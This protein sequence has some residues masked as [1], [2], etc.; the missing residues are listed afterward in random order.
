VP[1][2]GSRSLVKGPKSFFLQP[3]E[4][5]EK[6]EGTNHTIRK[7]NILAPDDGIWVTAVEEFH[8]TRNTSRV[9]KLP[10]DVWL[11]AGPGL[12][13]TPIEARIQKRIKAFLKFEP[14]N[15][16]FFQPGLFFGV[17]VVVLILLYLLLFRS[18]STVVQKDL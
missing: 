8:E 12:Y 5:L 17:I 6:E 10:G 16:Y 4:S 2:L 13:F 3:G 7:A 1:Q 18:V 9:K 14:L 15:L 11:I